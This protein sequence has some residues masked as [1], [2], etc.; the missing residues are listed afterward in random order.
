MYSGGGKTMNIKKP[1]NEN[2][3]R[4]PDIEIG[5]SLGAKAKNYDIK[6]AVGN[7]YNFVEGTKI[8]NCE[9][10]AGN[11]TKRPLHENVAEGLTKQYGGNPEK[12]QHAKGN[13][14]IDYYGDEIK[15]EVHWFQEPTVGKV[16]FIIKRWLE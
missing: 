11:G 15:A 9:I 12:W 14:I 3:L 10:F 2:V 7:I 16:K 4:L 13:G 1:D 8:Q 5:R 6:D